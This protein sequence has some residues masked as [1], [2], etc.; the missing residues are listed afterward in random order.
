MIPVRNDE[1]DTTT[2]DMTIT[3]DLTQKCVLYKTNSSTMQQDNTS[4]VYAGVG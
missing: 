4:V 2:I 3:K 1:Q